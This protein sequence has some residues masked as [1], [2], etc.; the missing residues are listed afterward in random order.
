MLDT[1]Y[2]YLPIILSSTN[3][4]TCMLW[5][6]ASR[7]NAVL[8]DVSVTEPVIPAYSTSLDLVLLLSLNCVYSVLT[9]A[10]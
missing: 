8:Y 9:L 2:P 10:G 5:H 3:S 6:C 4:W 7:E 1:V